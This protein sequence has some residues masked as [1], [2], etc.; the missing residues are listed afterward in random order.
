MKVSMDKTELADIILRYGDKYIKHHEVSYHQQK[1]MSAIRNCRTS[2][3]GGHIN[4]CDHCGHKD[5]SYNSCRNRNCPKCGQTKQL[6]WADK[7]AASLM[8]VRYFHIVFTLPH[9]LSEI[10]LANQQECYNILFKTSVESLQQ[11]ALNPEYLGAETGCI[12]VLHTWGQNLQ[13]H[14]HIHMIVPAG[15]LTVDGIEWKRSSKKFYIPVKALSKMFRAKFLEKLK[16]SN[17]K[18]ELQLPE[19]VDLEKLIG[20]LKKKN[21]NVH[22]KPA[23]SGPRQVIN[24]LGRY[25]NRVAITNNRII[26]IEDGKVRFLWKNY[27]HNGQWEKMELDAEEFLGRFLLHILPKGYYK[28]RYFGILASANSKTKRRQC[29]LLLGATPATPQYHEMTWNGIW[30]EA[31]QVDFLLCPVCKQGRMIMKENIDTHRLN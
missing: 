1:V 22:S 27:R 25:T 28:I 9:E 13:F 6:Q 30:Q 20:M 23:F 17:E 10:V 7:L 4:E 16:H 15:G 8:P 11:A 29:F 2:E 31:K 3:M 18:E 5:I 21:W 24:Y 19:Q 12:A 14:P 26:S